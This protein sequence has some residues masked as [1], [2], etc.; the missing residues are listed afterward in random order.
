VNE[1][2]VTDLL[3]ERGFETVVCSRLGLADQLRAF[4]EAEVVLGPHGAGLAN[5]CAS[6]TATVIELHRED[7]TTRPCYFAQAN[8]QGLEYWYMRC[9]PAGR[10]DLHVDPLELERTLDAAGVV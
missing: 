7:M 4:A 8:A 5:L 1:S 10:A 6:T 3:G 9:E 2:E